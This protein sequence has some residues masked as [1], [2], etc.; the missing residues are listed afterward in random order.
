MLCDLCG[1]T[2]VFT[3][4]LTKHRQSHF[5]DRPEQCP[6]CPKAFKRKRGLKEHMETHVRTTIAFSIEIIFNIKIFNLK[7]FSVEPAFAC[8]FCDKRFK[9]KDH[10][11]MHEKRHREDTKKFKCTF[12]P[13]AFEFKHDFSLHLDRKHNAEIPHDKIRK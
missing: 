12:C 13:A 3:H 10:C 2:F 7:Q 1:K 11:R 6:H 9:R 4:N 5:D 8:V